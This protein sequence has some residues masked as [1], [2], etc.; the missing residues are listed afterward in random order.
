MIL[1][2]GAYRRAQSRTSAVI[3]S[4]LEVHIAF[5]SVGVPF[6]PFPRETLLGSAPTSVAN[7]DNDGLARYK[8]T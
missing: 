7:L 2:N 4:F 8:A 3:C 1:D 6:S 5:S